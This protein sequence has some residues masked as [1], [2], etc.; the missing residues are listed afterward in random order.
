MSNGRAAHGVSLGDDAYQIRNMAEIATLDP[1]AQVDRGIV[2][3]MGDLGRHRSAPDLH[4][5][6]EQDRGRVLVVSASFE[7]RDELRLVVHFDKR[8]H[9]PILREAALDRDSVPIPWLGQRKI[10][11]TY[12]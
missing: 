6:A 3:D 8:C 5:A 11:F 1:D 4:E 2:V 10:E 12:H 9:N 7:P